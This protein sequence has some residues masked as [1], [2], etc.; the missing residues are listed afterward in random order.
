MAFNAAGAAELPLTVFGGRVT[1]MAAETLPQGVSPDNADV[2]FLAGRVFSRPCLQKTL[3]VPF[4]ANAAGVVPTVMSMDTYTTPLGDVTNLYLDSNGSLWSE[5]VSNSPG[6]YTLIG[7]VTPGSYFKGVSAYGRKYLGISD[8]L[9]GSDIPL[10]WD[11]TYLDRVTQDGPGSSPNFASVSLPGVAMVSTGAPPVLTVTE[12]DPENPQ[13]DGYFT[14][15]A[16]FVQ[17]VGIAQPGDTV[18]IAGNTQAAFNI[19]FTI[20]AVYAPTLL[21]A[22]AYIAPG[23]T[24]G[25]GGTATLGSGVT[26]QRAGN[27]VSVSCAAAHQLRPGYQAQ[28]SGVNATVVGGAITSIVVA[29]ENNPGVALVT[30]TTPHG[31]VPNNQVSI[32]GV[33]APSVGGGITS[34][35]RAGGVVTAVTAAAHGLSPGVLVTIAGAGGTGFNGAVAVVQVV[36]PTTFTYAQTDADGTAAAGGTVSLNWPIPESATPTYFT[37]Q[38]VPSPTTFLVALAYAD[39]TWTGGQ[40]TFGWVGTF[41]VLTVPSA[42]SFTYQQ[43]GPNAVT[44]NVGTVTP[45]GQLAP[46]PHQGQVLFLTRQGAITRGSPPVTFFSNGGQYLDCSNLPIGPPNVVGRIIAL[47]GAYGDYFFYSPTAPIVQG[48][49]VGTATVVNDN[50]STGILI[51]ISDVQLYSALGVSIPGNNLAGQIVLDGAL[52][53]GFYADRLW[54]WGQRNRVQN[55]VNLGFDGGYFPAT[56]TLPTGWA[57]QDNLGRLVPGRWGSAWTMQVSPGKNCGV[58]TQSAFQDGYGAPILTGNTQYQARF[59]LAASAIASDVTFTVAITS[60]STGFVSTA[61]VTGLNIGT[62][63][64]W[65]TAAFS[66]ATPAAIPSDMILSIYGASTASTLQLTVDEIS[67]IFAQDPFSETLMFGSYVGNPEGFNGLTGKF[68]SSTDANKIMAMTKNRGIMYFLTRDPKGQLHEV[69][70][71]AVTEPAG[72]TTRSVGSSC[73]ALSAFGLTEDAD[74]SPSGPDW[75]AWASTS[76]AQIFFGSQ[77]VKIS[78]EI[79]PDW[80][81]INMAAAPTVW[82][83]ND[84]LNRVAYFGVPTGSTAA[85]LVVLPVSYRELESGYEIASGAPVRVS[86]SGRL[87]AT[88]KTRKWT[89][90][91]LALNCGAMLPRA[92]SE[93]APCFGCGNSEAPG[94]PGYGNAYALNYAKYTDDDYGTVS[95]YYVTSYFPGRE[96]EEVLQLGGG[97]KQLCYTISLVSGVGNLEISLI[98]NVAGNLYPINLVT[99]LSAAPQNDTEWSGASAQGYR[100]ALK[101]QSVP[102]AGATDNAFSLTKTVVYMRQSKHTPVR[103]AL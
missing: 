62:V 20:T 56:P 14:A 28:I 2:A 42:T 69:Q 89:V 98:V 85:P 82:A 79:Q 101:Y 83:F 15:V 66:L 16:V 36:N 21:W 3:N 31:L 51:D 45:W 44:T 4:P 49:A 27:I 74:D 91:N 40:I 12:I 5:D 53:F 71:S 47:T 94:T 102:L 50:V 67:I 63:P 57:S 1:D 61:T 11:G 18:T 86:F 73:G 19:T 75:F 29:N 13:P 90:W 80:N 97:I 77:P 34:L 46:G 6:N 9:H 32:T 10:Q 87:I 54:T 55:F 41:L 72:W 76:G 30:T 58:L 17:S 103:S 38:S 23:T 25:T 22:T 95:P 96:L 39:G 8:G 7:S 43:Y 64:T 37:V 35:S 59:L 24:F 48:Q 68:G 65:F 93:I 70:D 78:Q 92:N 100:I 60:A 99:P 26:M 88:D 52:G 84:W 33:T 81:S